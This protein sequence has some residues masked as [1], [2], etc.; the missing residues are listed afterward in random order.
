MELKLNFKATLANLGASC[1]MNA[2]I[3][4]LARSHHLINHLQMSGDSSENLIVELKDLINLFKEDAVVAPRR[5]FQFCLQGASNAGFH[6][7][8]K[9]KQNDAHEYILYLLTL[10][11]SLEDLFRIKTKNMVQCS[12]CKHIHNV[13]EDVFIFDINP[14]F[15][16]LKEAIIN[17][18]KP[19]KLEDYVCDNCKQV[20]V[21]KQSLLGELPSIFLLSLKKYHMVGRSSL[22]YPDEFV[23]NGAKYILVS[24]ICHD[25]DLGGGHYYTIARNSPTS[26]WIN[27][28]DTHKSPVKNYNL[29]S[30]YILVYDKL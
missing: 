9:V 15:G 24:I 17:Y 20:N 16:N 7:L 11:K 10:G 22:T 12:D 14:I 23:I 28:N 26:E 6:E 4:A 19:E 1:Y 5:F 18:F 8:S 13:V 27:Y 29:K 25:G 2:T 30:A 3:Q 21:F